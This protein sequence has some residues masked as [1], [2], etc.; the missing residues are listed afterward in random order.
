MEDDFFALGG[1]SLLATRIAAR[2]SKLLDAEVALAA[3]FGAPTVAALVRALLQNE[4]EP[5][6]LEAVAGVRLRMRDMRENGG[7]RQSDAR[8]TFPGEARHA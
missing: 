4:A 5:R 6:R 7:R 2:L 1:H 3:I 8:G